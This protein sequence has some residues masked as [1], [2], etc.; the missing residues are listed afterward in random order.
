MGKNYSYYINVDIGYSNLGNFR[1]LKWFN[2]GKISDC[3]SF[4]NRKFNIEILY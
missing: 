1:Y 4:L 2:S 3:N